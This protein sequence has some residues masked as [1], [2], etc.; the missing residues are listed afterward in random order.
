MYLLSA[1][2]FERFEM[3]NTIYGL[4]SSLDKAKEAI[5]ILVE[6]KYQD[7][8]DAEYIEWRNYYRNCFKITPLPNVDDL[9]F[10]KNCNIPCFDKY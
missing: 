9:D 2:Y 1:Q 10:F 5:E 3:K 8:D 6:R 7:A 4:F